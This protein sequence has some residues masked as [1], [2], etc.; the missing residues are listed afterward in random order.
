MSA[1]NVVQ[2]LYNLSKDPNNREAIV[3]DQGCLPGLVMFLRDSNSDTQVISM[4]L[5]TLDLL[6]EH[7][8][9]K[10]TMAKEPGLVSQLQNILDSYHSTP[11]QLE[12]SNKILSKIQPPSN[13][14]N[15]NI[16][17][18][19]IA[20]NANTNTAKS[21]T[22]S[23]L[24][25]EKLPIKD[26]LISK[27]PVNTNN[28]NNNSSNNSSSKPIQTFIFH[29][30]GMNTQAIKTQVEDCLLKTRGVI[31]FMIDLH[32]YQATIRTS[33]TTDELK[34]TIR[35]NI[36]LS[37]SL[38]VDGQE[39]SESLPDYLPEPTKDQNSQKGAKGSWGW[40]SIISFGFQDQG[41]SKQSQNNRGGWGSSISKALFG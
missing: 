40:G 6:S 33:L 5:E 28:N 34:M 19:N 13:I 11:E 31:S 7:N 39:E 17:T 2:Q 9:N 26:K 16:N 27:P 38:V 29:I 15:E 21:T 22:F 36:G 37:A 8:N 12:I 4:T 18:S 3:R 10:S 24:I 35:N 1:L 30:K 20:S 23:M 14:N 41:Q 32:T 25:G